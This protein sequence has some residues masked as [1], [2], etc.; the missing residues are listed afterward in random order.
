MNKSPKS[1]KGIPNKDVSFIIETCERLKCDP[2]EILCYVANGDWKSLG[3]KGPTQQ[4]VGMGGVKVEVPV[5]Q[6]DHRIDSAKKLMDFIYPKRKAIE[7]T[8]P[9]GNDKG[10]VL[11]YNP[12]TLKSSNEPK[13]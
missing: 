6:L 13:N 9:S 11:A 3:Y 1:R 7:I 2:V 12:A 8:D 4:Q 5:I 10:F